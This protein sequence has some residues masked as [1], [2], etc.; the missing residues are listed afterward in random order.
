MSSLTNNIERAILCSIIFNNDNFKEINTFLKKEDFPYA[1]YGKI[2]EIMQE[3]DKKDIPIEELFLVKAGADERAIIE[4]MSANA[5]TNVFA[6]AKDLKKDSYTKKISQLSL[7]LSQEF[8]E[9][10]LDEIQRLKEELKELDDV[11]KLKSF[12]EKSELFFDTMDLNTDE[13]E[14]I[15]FNYLYDYFIVK[16]EI[17]MIAARSGIGKSLNT[18]ALT[19]M[20][21]QN[22]KVARCFYLDGDNGLSTLKERKI[23]KVKEYYGKRLRYTQGKSQNEFRR[24]IGELEKYDLTDCL[25][26]FDSM[27][28]FMFGGDRDKNKDVSKVMDVLKKLRNNG[29]TVIFLHHTNKPQKDIND[30]MY[31]GSSAWEEDA[32]NAFIL[33]RNEDKNA[34]IFH[35]IKARSGELHEIAFS[36]NSESHTLTKLEL[37]YAKETK[38]DQELQNEIIDFISNSRQ[39]PIWSEIYNH[40][41]ENGYEKNKAST[42]IKIGEGKLWNIT[43][44][45]NNKKIYSLIKKE[46][47]KTT[48]KTKTEKVASGTPI[49]SGSPFYGVSHLS[50]SFSGTPISQDNLLT[51]PLLTADVQNFVEIPFIE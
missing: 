24:N 10:Y 9:D 38:L 13:V 25:V 11:R 16:N 12:D 14:N 41:L 5:I 1:P 20:F 3:L 45:N 31:A 32:S 42:A 17:T 46:P 47:V 28:N 48:F 33:K 34:F 37:E 29:A 18:F 2:Y 26:V 39:S 21:L 35:N 36:Y 8:K 15:T 22:N 40:L 19:N 51:S 23:H 30:L 49:T 4:V 50:D 7:K 6:Y 43:R 27:K 44:G